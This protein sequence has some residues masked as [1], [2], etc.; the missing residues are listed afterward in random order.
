MW[1][2]VQECVRKIGTRDWILWVTRGC[3][4]PETAH[5]PVMLEVEASCQ[6]EHYK[7][8]KDNWP[9]NYLVVG[10]HD[11][12]KLRASPVLKNLTL[13]ISFLPQYKYPFYPQKKES[14]QREFWERNPR[15][16]I[17]LIH[18]QSSLR[19]FTNSSTLFLSIVKSLR[20]LLLKTF[21]TISISVKGL[22]GALGS[23]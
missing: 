11:S 10:T 2:N 21:L 23:N 1:R 7:T 14:F 17:R 16:K 22:F 19:D 12:V 4:S 15:E 8:K 6:L 18:S 20:G 13:H 3:K 9:F 5:V